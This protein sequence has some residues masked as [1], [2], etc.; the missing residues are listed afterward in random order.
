M[1]KSLG[2]II[3]VSLSLLVFG[4]KSDGKNPNEELKKEVIGI[5]DEVMP[6]MGNLKSLKTK[7][8]EKSASLSKE[9]SPNYDRIQKLELLAGELDSAFEGMFVWMRQFKSDFEGMSSDEVKM[10]LLDQKLKVEKVNVDIKETIAIAN[11][12]LKVE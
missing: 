12:A 6:L 11:E 10:Y 3:L 9:E 1:C 7:V 5:H 2:F 4:C 8:L